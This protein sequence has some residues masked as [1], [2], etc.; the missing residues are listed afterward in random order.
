MNKQKNTRAIA[1]M[2]I[3]IA[4]SY[5]SLYLIRFPLISSAP[6]LRFD[7]KDVFITIGGLILGPA[8]AFAGGIVVSILQIFTVSEYGIVG[9]I[10]NLLSVSAFVLPVSIICYKKKSTKALLLGLIFS[11]ITMTITMLA[12]NF[13]IS[14]LYM[15]VSRDIIKDM[16]LPVFLPFNAIKSVINAILIFITWNILKKCTPLEKLK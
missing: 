16:L 8:Y 12:W 10:M 11:C 15:G 13:L 6:F 3:L 9:L 7:I 4:I 2:G 5:A 14:P 1:L